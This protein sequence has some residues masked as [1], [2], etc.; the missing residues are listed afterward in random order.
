MYRN[1][2]VTRQIFG[3]VI[4]RFRKQT[5]LLHTCFFIVSTIFIINIVVIIIIIIITNIIIVNF[6]LISFSVFL[7]TL[8]SFLYKKFLVYATRFSDKF[9]FRYF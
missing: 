5:F 6:L 3:V 2:S 1:R 8:I 7:G 4:Y 9:S